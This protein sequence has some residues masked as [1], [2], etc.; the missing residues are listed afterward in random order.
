MADIPSGTVT[1]FFTDIEGSTKLA[2]VYPDKWESLREKHHAILKEAI[3]S[4]NGCIFQIIGDAFCAAFH[5]A[6]DGLNA[7]IE[8]Q[9]ALKKTSEFFENS[10]VSLRARMGIHTG[11]AEARDGEYRGYLTLSMV[12]RVMSAGHGGQILVSGVRSCLKWVKPRSNCSMSVRRKS[13]TNRKRRNVSA[14]RSVLR[15]RCQT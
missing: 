12:Q 9:H 4:N 7:A 14:G 8:A 6:K 2:Q 10:E 11:E 13:L 3:E 5:T 15:C 1:F